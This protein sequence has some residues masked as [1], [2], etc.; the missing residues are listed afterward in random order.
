MTGAQKLDGTE[1]K[2][3]KLSNMALS[4]T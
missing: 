3:D 1:Q 4:S 2:T